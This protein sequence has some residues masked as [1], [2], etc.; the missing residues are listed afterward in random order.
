MMMQL[1]PFK[2]K[3]L[4]ITDEMII[5]ENKIYP[6]GYSFGVARFQT[7]EPIVINKMWTVVG[8]NT[9]IGAFLLAKDSEL[10]QW[11]PKSLCEV[12]S[13]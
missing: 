11:Y 7:I 13:I 6:H 8:Y 12:V 5:E 9:E 4:P 10:T 3:C 1:I 2:V